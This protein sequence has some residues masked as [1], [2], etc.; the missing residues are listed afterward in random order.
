[1]ANHLRYIIAILNSIKDLERMADYGVSAIRFFANNKITNDI[2]NLVIEILKGALN[3]M[4]KVFNSLKVKPAIDT[5]KICQHAHVAFKNNYNKMV[6]KLSGIL[7]DHT[8]EQIERLFHGAII[9]IKH[10]ERLMDHV[11]NIAENFVFIKQPD[12]FFSKHSKQIDKA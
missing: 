7:K 1:M 10:I 2:R 5:Y 8:A 4:L 11:A 12:L 6:E 9:I 3:G